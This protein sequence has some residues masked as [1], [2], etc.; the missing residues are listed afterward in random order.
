[1]NVMSQLTFINSHHI[2]VCNFLYELLLQ[3][4]ANDSVDTKLWAL[5]YIDLQQIQLGSI[6]LESPSAISSS[7][8]HNTLA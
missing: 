4:V 1:M 3:I 5:S 8:L 7:L 6:H 2:P